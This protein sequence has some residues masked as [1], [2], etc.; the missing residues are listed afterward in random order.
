MIIGNY[1]NLSYLGKKLGFIWS[2]PL[3]DLWYV[4]KIYDLHNLPIKF[5]FSP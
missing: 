1:V 4:Y 3:N 2:R 5:K